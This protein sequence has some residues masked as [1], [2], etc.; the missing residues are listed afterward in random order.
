MSIKMHD[1]DTEPQN[2]TA[3]QK[4]LWFHCPG[5]ECDHG[6]HVPQWTWNGSMESPTFAPS[7]ICN[8]DDPKSRCHAIITDGNIQFCGDSYHK[9]AGQTV[10]MPDWEG[11]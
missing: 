7:L 5:C 6:I 10:P 3:T 9:L 8:G 1:S 11:W 2:A 4:V